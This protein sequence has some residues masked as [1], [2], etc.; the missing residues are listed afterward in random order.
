MTGPTG[1]E[2]GYPQAGKTRSW[3][4]DELKPKDFGRSEILL[5]VFCV[6]S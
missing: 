4:S 1:L 3:E 2:I 6:T 5:V